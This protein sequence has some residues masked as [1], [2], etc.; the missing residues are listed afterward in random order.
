MPHRIAFAFISRIGEDSDVESA[1]GENP[2]RSIFSPVSYLARFDSGQPLGLF[3]HQ[4][5]GFDV[6]RRRL[7]DPSGWLAQ[8]KP[9]LELS[10]E[11]RLR[12]DSGM[13]APLELLRLADAERTRFGIAFSAELEQ[14]RATHQACA[15]NRLIALNDDFCPSAS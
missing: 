2:G 9:Q 15:G 4:N 5:L 13:A 6:R 7:T 8:N 11:A 3:R 10:P 14:L 1:G 12:V